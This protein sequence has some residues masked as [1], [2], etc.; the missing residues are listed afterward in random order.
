MCRVLFSPV[1]LSLLV[2]DVYVP[3]S[4]TSSYNKN[5]AESARQKLDRSYIYIDSCT[6]MYM[7][8]FDEVLGERLKLTKFWREGREEV[9]CLGPFF[10]RVSGPCPG[11]GR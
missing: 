4:V 6:C 9:V 3:S 7:C 2:H 10:P 8:I 1:S 5:V 11:G